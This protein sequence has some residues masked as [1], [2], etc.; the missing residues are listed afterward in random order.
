MK[1]ISVKRAAMM[2]EYRALQMALKNMAGWRSEWS[3]E[4]SSDLECHHIDGRQ[5]ARLL[6][7]FNIIVLTQ[8]EHRVFQANNSWPVRA[9]LAA[10][11]EPIRKQQ[12]EK[13]G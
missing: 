5:N 1:P 11:V 12:F 13:E 4:W 3:G 6:D 7:P 8:R 2:G 10:W 9:A